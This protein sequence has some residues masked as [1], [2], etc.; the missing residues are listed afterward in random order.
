MIQIPLAL[1]VTVVI[2]LHTLLTHLFNWFIRKTEH[3]PVVYIFHFIEILLINN[4][5]YVTHI[6]IIMN[7][8]LKEKGV[9]LICVISGQNRLK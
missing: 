8:L 9:I 5:N 6:N 7:Y 2:L 4:K 3:E 1:A